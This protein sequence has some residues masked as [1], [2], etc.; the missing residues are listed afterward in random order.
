MENK[1]L[2]IFKLKAM[3][4][5][6]HIPF[7]FKIRE[8]GVDK[9]YQICYPKDGFR[10]KCSVIQGNGT[11]GGEKDLLEITGLLTDTEENDGVLGYLTAE[12]VF[13]RIEKDFFKNKLWRKLRNK[14]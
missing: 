13:D 4:E 5:E 3:L 7:E 8:F 10:R 12:N 11:Y 9:I 2:A 6:S 1:Y 14:H